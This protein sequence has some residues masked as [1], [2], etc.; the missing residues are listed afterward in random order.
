MDDKAKDKHVA[1]MLDFVAQQLSF[2][3][4]ECRLQDNH[5]YPTTFFE[6]SRCTLLREH[7]EWGREKQP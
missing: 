1:K 6:C 7:K 3:K 2:E 4:C 5:R